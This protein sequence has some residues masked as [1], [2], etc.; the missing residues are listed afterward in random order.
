MLLAAGADVGQRGVNDYT[1]LHLA[2]AQGDLRAV[3]ILLEAG[4]D[5]N[6][7]TRIDDLET[8]LEVAAAGEHRRIV[9]RLRPLST[10]GDSE[11][12]S[13]AGGV[14]QLANLGLAGP[15]SG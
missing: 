4:S 14:P 15:D 10:R 5:P 7:I 2:A 6:E 11:D 13:E 9:D 12:A 8:P 1:P 3:D